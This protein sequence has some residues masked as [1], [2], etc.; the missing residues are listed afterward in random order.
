MPPDMQGMAVPMETAVSLA[1]FYTRDNHSS[2]NLPKMQQ[3]IIKGDT[4]SLQLLLTS[5]EVRALSSW[6]CEEEW[7]DVMI[8]PSRDRC[9]TTCTIHFHLISTIMESVTGEEV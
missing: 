8:G 6:F 9:R 3:A 7:Y 4:S 5:A 2:E 1:H